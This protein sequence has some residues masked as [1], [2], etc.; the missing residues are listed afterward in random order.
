MKPILRSLPKKL[1]AIIIFLILVVIVLVIFVFSPQR[2][3]Q[4]QQTPSLLPTPFLGQVEFNS[5]PEEPDIHQG[6]D[7]TPQIIWKISNPNLRTSARIYKTQYAIS[8]NQSAAIARQFGFTSQP[9]MFVNE[10]TDSTTATWTNFPKGL[11]LSI[12]QTTGYIEYLNNVIQGKADIDSKPPQTL[13]SQT[14][15]A[16]NARTFLSSHGLLPP[17]VSTSTNNVKLFNETQHHPEEVDSFP[18]ATLYQVVFIQQVDNIPVYIQFGNPLDISV[19]MTNTNIVKKISFFFTQVIG[20]SNPQPLLTFNQIQ[21]Q[22]DSGNG[23]IYAIGDEGILLEDAAL[24]S[25]ELTSIQLVYLDDRTSGYLHPYY[26]LKGQETTTN[27]E[28]RIYLS[29]VNR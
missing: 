2:T 25:I 26:L 23:I 17:N 3:N 14:Q 11:T 21:K 1:T 5:T 22:I 19:W 24:N 18:N 9:E 16:E 6:N 12:T 28:V 20:G 8:E 27:N 29:A 10:F 4:P 15:V 7:S 13:E